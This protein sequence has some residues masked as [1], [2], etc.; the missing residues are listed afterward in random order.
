MEETRK[1]AMAVT[2][3]YVSDPRVMRS[4]MT[5]GEAGFA[6]EVVARR[7]R[8]AKPTSGSG[9][10][11]MKERGQG[12]GNRECGCDEGKNDCGNSEGGQVCGQGEGKK[13]RGQ[14]EGKKECGNSEGKVDVAWIKP[15]AQSGFVFYAEFNVRLFWRLMWEKADGFYAN[16]SDT[17]MACYCAARMRKKVLIFDAHELFPEVPELVGRPRVK[18]FWERLEQ[19]ILTRMGKKKR[20]W[21]ALTVSESI[22]DYYRER[23]GVEMAVVRNVPRG[24]GALRKELAAE[25]RKESEVLLYEGAV[26]KGRGVRQMMDAMEFL[27]EYRFVVAGDGD[28]MAELTTYRNGLEWKERIELMGHKRPEEL[29][30]LASGAALGLVMMEPMGLSYYYSLPN[31]VALFAHA[32]VPVLASDFPEIARVVK[33][34]ELGRLVECEPSIPEGKQLAEEVRKALEEWKM[35]DDATKKARMERVRKELCWERDREVL[36]AEVRRSF[37]MEG[38]K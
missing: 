15:L 2:T 22:A 17:L 34:Y 6:V 26:N 10:E 18:R 4:S 7:K 1:I 12:E 29:M 28:E 27:P 38:I 37:G 14:G 9:I 31:R 35:T 8:G 20:G 33:E 23:Y 24:K 5:L 32:G 25:E 13:E 19:R 3:D 16:D 30:R 21:G 36:I 11:G